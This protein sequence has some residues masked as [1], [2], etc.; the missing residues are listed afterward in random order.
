MKKEKL[1]I[2]NIW[3]FYSCQINNYFKNMQANI[4][5]SYGDLYAEASKKIDAIKI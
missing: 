2:K 4:Q 5:A 1:K 3:S